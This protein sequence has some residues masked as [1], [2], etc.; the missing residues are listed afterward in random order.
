[1]R[2]PPRPS[3]V[4]GGF[5]LGPVNFQGLV[6][7]PRAVPDSQSRIRF[8][9]QINT[10]PNELETNSNDRLYNSER[11][12]VFFVVV[13]V[14]CV[15]VVIVVVVVVISQ[16]LFDGGWLMTRREQRKPPPLNTR[17]NYLYSTSSLRN[18]PRSPRFGA[19][20]HCSRSR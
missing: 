12:E 9:N 5:A 17:M 8:V 14:V 18:G 15:V 7:V 10:V 13:D 6:S 2:G 11:D 19:S 16:V 1:M 3:R 20:R 4:L